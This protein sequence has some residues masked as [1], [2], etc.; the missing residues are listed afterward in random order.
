MT[1]LDLLV[2]Q[3]SLSL[4]FLHTDI[5]GIDSAQYSYITNHATKVVTGNN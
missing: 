5:L 2:A 3:F 4:D 1:F